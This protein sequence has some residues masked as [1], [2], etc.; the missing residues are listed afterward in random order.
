VA[1]GYLGVSTQP[2]QRGGRGAL[3]AAVQRGGPAER[4]GI[5]PGDVVVR[6]GDREIAQPSDLTA[7]TIELEPGQR[8]AVTVQRNGRRETKDVEL[9][10][11]PPMQRQPAGRR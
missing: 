6:L 7:A 5:T 10:R 3:I 1:R 8:V 2:N 4:A 9:G 11:R